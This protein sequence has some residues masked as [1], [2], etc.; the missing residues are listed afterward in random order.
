MGLYI[1]MPGGVCSSLRHFPPNPT[2]RFSFLSHFF[3]KARGIIYGG[4]AKKGFRGIHCACRVYYVL[5]VLSVFATIAKESRIVGICHSRKP[6]KGFYFKRQFQPQA[7]DKD[8]LVFLIR[9]E[10]GL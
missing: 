7:N 3:R 8:L 2:L 1:Y 5:T 4:R 9:R 10:E 6:I